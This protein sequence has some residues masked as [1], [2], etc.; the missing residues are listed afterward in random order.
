LEFDIQIVFDRESER[1]LEGE[2]EI[3]GTQEIVEALGVFGA[4]RRLRLSEGEGRREKGNQ[5]QRRGDAEIG[6]R[7]THY[8]FASGFSVATGLT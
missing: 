4:D 3:A 2:I 5:T 7:E 8:L 6:E 1:V